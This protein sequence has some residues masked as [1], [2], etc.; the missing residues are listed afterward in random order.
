MRY[1]IHLFNDHRKPFLNHKENSNVGSKKEMKL[2]KPHSP[3]LS[4]KTRIRKEC[5]IMAEENEK[6]EKKSMTKP[7]NI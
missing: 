2:T 5:N 4:T 7:S 6:K 1:N 3:H